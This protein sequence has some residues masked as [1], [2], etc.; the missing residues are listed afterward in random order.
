MSR[1]MPVQLAWLCS[2]AVACFARHQLARFPSCDPAIPGHD[3]FLQD[4]LESGCRK[5]DAVAFY[6]ALGV[7]RGG[8]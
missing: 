3:A 6:V 5:E 7:A 1:H 8:S 2:F 4:R